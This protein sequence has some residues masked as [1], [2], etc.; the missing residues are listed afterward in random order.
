MVRFSRVGL[1]AVPMCHPQVIRSRQ[2]M[3]HDG[4]N[5]GKSQDHREGLRPLPLK[6]M[7]CDFFCSERP[8]TSSVRVNTRGLPGDRHKSKKASTS[9][10]SWPPSGP[11]SP[12]DALDAGC[13]DTRRLLRSPLWLL[14]TIRLAHT[15]AGCG[16]G[17]TRKRSTS[18]SVH[19]RSVSP[20]AMAGV[21]GCHCFAEPVPLV[22]SGCGRG[23]RTL[24]WGKQKL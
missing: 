16:H 13:V 3:R 1:A 20:A 21:Q 11:L 4:G 14:P 15:P 12:G 23:W 10:S 6:S 22:G 8:C 18:R 17:G 7:E 24:A 5:A 9:R 2:R 19:T